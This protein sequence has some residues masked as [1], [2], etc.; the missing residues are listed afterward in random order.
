MIAEQQ[1]QRMKNEYAKSGV[2]G[3]AAMKAGMDRETARK[4]LEA[5]QG[6]Q[7]EKRR[8]RRRADPLTAIWPAAERLLLDAPEVEAKALFEHLLGRLDQAQGQPAQKAVRTFQR[9]VLGR[10]RRCFSSRRGNRVQA[11]SWIGRMSR[12]WA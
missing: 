7:P 5:G 12:N 6:P 1:Y 9:R 8:S 11:C 2:L 4:Y 10:R 3:T